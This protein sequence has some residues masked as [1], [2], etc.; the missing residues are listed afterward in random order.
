[1]STAISRKA[2]YIIDL[3]GTQGSSEATAVSDC[4]REIASNGGGQAEDEHLVSCAE[5]IRNWA[6][7][8]IDRMARGTA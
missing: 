3:L 6:Q 8:F 2:K 7:C 5:E 4:L 1:M